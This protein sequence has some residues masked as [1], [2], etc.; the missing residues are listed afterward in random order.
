[1]ALTKCAE[2]GKEISDKAFA[3]P[4]CGA[5]TG[6]AAPAFGYEYRSKAMLGGL[7]LVH[8][9][10]GIDPATGRKRIAKGVIAIGDIAVGWL[11]IGGLAVGGIAL[12]G[13]ALGLIALGGAA[14][15]VLLALGGLAIGCVAIGGAAIG[16]Y[17][18]GGGAFAVHPLGA[19]AQDPEA[20]A[21]FKR[22]LGAW[23][24]K[25]GQHR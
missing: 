13:C 15:G 19:N 4:H 18:L 14:I 12:G 7:P 8:I 9:A 24:E 20:T 17:A 3:C 22:W 11:A 5:L 10:T 2:C 23:V 1:M 16:Y 25:L 21:F 6:K